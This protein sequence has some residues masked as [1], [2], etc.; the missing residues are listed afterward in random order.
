M[1]GTHIHTGR[2]THTSTS[3]VSQHEQTNSCGMPGCQADL[4]ARL[5]FIPPF[6]CQGHFFWHELLCAH[7]HAHTQSHVC[8]TSEDITLTLIYFLE[9]SPRRS[10]TLNLTRSFTAVQSQQ[11]KSCKHRHKCK[12]FSNSRN[13]NIERYRTEL[14]PA[15]SKSRNS[16]PAHTNCPVLLSI[17]KM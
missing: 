3:S 6:L 17:S 9:N 8:I 1:L 10:V 15:R 14:S 2:S 13:I 7:T 11:Q 16:D 12:I 5:L 4:V